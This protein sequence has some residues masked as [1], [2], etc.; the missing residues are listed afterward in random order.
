MAYI[1]HG[2]VNIF[3]DEEGVCEKSVANFYTADG[4]I[5]MLA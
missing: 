1:V 4:N 3:A 5:L 2:W